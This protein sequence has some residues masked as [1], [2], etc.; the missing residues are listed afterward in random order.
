MSKESGFKTNNKWGKPVE[1]APVVE[2]RWTASRRQEAVLRIFRAEPIEALSRELG[3]EQYRLTA[4]RDRALGGIESALR[5]RQTSDP[6]DAEFE[7]ALKRI[8][9]LSM[10]N[11]LL[12]V[13]CRAKD[14]SRRFSRC[15]W[16]CS[17]TLAPSG[18]MSLAAWPCASTTGR[19]TCRTTS[20]T[21]CDSGA[22]RPAS[23]S[24]AS[25]RPMASPSASSER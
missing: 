16:A 17:N 20:S 22:S 6:R 9:E 14:P 11:E 12:R 10:E 4:W 23:P 7:A 24:S 3:V 2:K 18:P 25:R 1:R 21:N 13:R 8:G 15:R 19:N 5:E